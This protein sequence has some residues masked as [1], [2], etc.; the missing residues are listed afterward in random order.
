MTIEVQLYLH[1][2][3]QTQSELALPMSIKLVD[4]RLIAG[5]LPISGRGIK[6]GNFST[7]WRSRTICFGNLPH[8]EPE[9]LIFDEI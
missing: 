9:S 7:K 3:C 1:L 6:I 8:N 2:V 5:W 4:C